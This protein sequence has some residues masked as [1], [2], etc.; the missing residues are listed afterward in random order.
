MRKP[1]REILE[2]GAAIVLSFG[3]SGTV[4][5]GLS[6]W[7]G[8]VWA[9]RILEQDRLRYQGELERVKNE[10]EATAKRLQGDIDK[11]IFVHRLHFET[12]F[13]ALRDIWQRVARVRATMALPLRQRD[14]N[15]KAHGAFEEASTAVTELIEKIDALSPFYPKDI[16]FELDKLRVQAT[17]LLSAAA[18]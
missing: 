18:G 17:G 2:I 1:M 12:E 8:K 16:Y 6:S 9:S 5:F 4:I 13:L 14:L 10:L 7:L 15:D 3:V 11:T